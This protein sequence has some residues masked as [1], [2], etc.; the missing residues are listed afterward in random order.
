[1]HKEEW[2]LQKAWD[3]CES[4]SRFG[5]PLHF[6]E[7]TILSGRYK[8]PDDNDW[9]A[10]PEGWDSTEEGEKKQLEYGSA[11]YTLLFS[12]PAVEA[13]TTWDFSDYGAWQAAP[14]GLIRKDMSPKPF[15]EWIHESFHKKWATNDSDT[16]DD[17]GTMT[18]R[19][20]FGDHDLK[21]RL[22][23]GEEKTVR[24]SVR[25]RGLRK[26]RVVV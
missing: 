21:V 23:S 6:T 25:R 26:M 9:H 7:L 1:M 3:V 19:C 12:H 8:A 10:R 24:V 5:M 2:P 18:A 22:P 15:Y 20:Y 13:I 16:T 17:A 4:Y 14:A 11:L